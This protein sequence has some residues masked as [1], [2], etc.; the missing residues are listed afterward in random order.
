VYGLLPYKWYTKNFGSSLANA[1]FVGKVLYP[2]QF[3]DV[4]P[5]A[6]ADDIYRFL[7]GKPVFGEM[8][9][10]FGRLAFKEVLEQYHHARFKCYPG[11]CW[12]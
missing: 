8:N 3:E 9:A 12:Q 10:Q 7:V 5:S 4:N 2:E 11:D 1:Y 6:K